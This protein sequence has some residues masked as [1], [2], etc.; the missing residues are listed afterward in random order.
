MQYEEATVSENQK[1]KN[2]KSQ[3]AKTWK[4][5][6]VP[7]C[8]LSMVPRMNI[9]VEDKEGT[10]EQQFIKAIMGQKGQMLLVLRLWLWFNCL[11]AGI[12]KHIKVL[13]SK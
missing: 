4:G 3:K 8:L 10:S 12:E 5:S 6:F 9:N 1:K 11:T 7:W 13:V 2:Q